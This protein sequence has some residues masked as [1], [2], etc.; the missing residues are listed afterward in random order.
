[1]SRAATVAVPHRHESPPPAPAAA[2]TAV[3]ALLEG[4]PREGKVLAA[5]PS[6]VYVEMGAETE[7]RVIALVTP[8]AVRLP[9]AAVLAGSCPGPLTSARVGGHAVVG[10]GEMHVGALHTHVARWW[11]PAPKV[12]AV[13]PTT[14]HRRLTELRALLDHAPTPPGLSGHTVPQT[15][16]TACAQ[17]DL[18]H[19]VDAA[20]RLVGLGPGLTPSGDDLLAGLLLSL[21]VLGGGLTHEPRHPAGD[22]QALQ[23]AEP[24]A[25]TVMLADWL[26]AEVTRD[27]HTRTTAVAATLLHCAARGQATAEV[28]AVLAALAGHDRL[29]PSMRRLL[30]VGHTSGADLGWG[31][32]AGGL[33][34]LR[35]VRP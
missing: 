11:D 13:A 25:D 30:A 3:R 19:A 12:G 20:E 27:A 9:V 21:R 1:M 5:F 8:S 16:A 26:G 10:G 29:E 31:L 24:A 15:L 17:G 22:R 32:L 35:Q 7:P 28:G 23:S 18:A 33:A 6:A 14:L 34:C 4:P 2:S